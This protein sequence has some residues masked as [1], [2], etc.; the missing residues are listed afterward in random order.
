MSLLNAMLLCIYYIVYFLINL[1][2]YFVI[3]KKSLFKLTKFKITILNFY[4]L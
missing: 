1:F 2:I 3:I 4:I